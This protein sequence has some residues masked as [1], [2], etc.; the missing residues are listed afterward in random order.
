MAAN[1]SLLPRILILAIIVSP[2]ILVLLVL[3][4]KEPIELR[5]K[6]IAQ[7]N[8]GFLTYPNFNAGSSIC[9]SDN[10]ER[11][12]D[13]DLPPERMWK[14]LALSALY[15]QQPSDALLKLLDHAITTWDEEDKGNDE[16]WNLLPI[17]RA[18]Q[19]TNNKSFLESFLLGI[20][21]AVGATSM[22]YSDQRLLDSGLYLLSPLHRSLVYSKKF[23][24]DDALMHELYPDPKAFTYM[25]SYL[26]KINALIDR[27]KRRMEEKFNANNLSGDKVREFVESNGCWFVLSEGTEAEVT[28]TLSQFEKTI[29]KLQLDKLDFARLEGRPLQDV[30]PCVESLKM[31]AN[32]NQFVWQPIYKQFI[33][34]IIDSQYDSSLRPLCSGNDSFLTIINPGSPSCVGNIMSVADNSWMTYLLASSDEIYNLSY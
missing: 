11:Q 21:N 9:Y 22:F 24:A 3:L 27:L 33:G 25:K 26:P 18:Y 8:L 12:L 34:K 13:K 29:A 14:V 2:L 23:F 4:K 30:L 28:S 16:M 32:Y 10:C 19:A 5:S 7:Q 1:R 20:T 31:L 15:K 17:F 6:V